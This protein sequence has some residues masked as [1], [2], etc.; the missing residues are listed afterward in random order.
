[1]EANSLLKDFQSKLQAIKESFVIEINTLQTG[2]AHPSLLD[3]ITVE[4]YGSKLA[5]NQL[6]SITISDAAT[7]KIAPFDNANIV[8]ISKAI[9]IFERSDFN[10][11]DDGRIVY[12]RVP[13]LTTERRHQ[14]VKSLHVVR[15]SF[16]VRLRQARHHILKEIKELEEAEE[17]FKGHQRQIDTLSSQAKKEIDDLAQV[18]E[19]EILEL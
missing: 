15:E 7:L 3:G 19:K 4:V 5:L 11:T 16:H 14:I 8:L 13:P 9:A 2:R 10:P 17:D 1:M 12:V 18:K 6:A